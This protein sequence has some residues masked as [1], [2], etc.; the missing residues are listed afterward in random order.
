MEERNKE[1]NSGM[2]ENK[3]VIFSVI[4]P[5]YKVEYYLARCV[6]SLIQ[7]SVEKDQ[8]E[9]LLVDDGSPD[10]SGALCDEYAEKYLFVKAFHKENGGLSSARNYG[11]ERAS[12]EWILFVDSD[13]YVDK[14]LCRILQE[15]IQRYPGLDAVVYNGL[16]EEEET[17]SLMRSR[18]ETESV[19]SGKEYLLRHYKTR[20]LSVEACLYAYRREFLKSN[21]LQFKE[22]ILHEDVE[23][24]PRAM[25]QA[26][27]VLELDQPLYHYIIRGDSI[28]TAK[29]MQ[30]NIRDLY[31]TLEQQV[32]IAEHQPPELQKW[33][34]N[35][36]LD[37]Y[38]N[39]VQTARMYQKK[40]R[41]LL[42]KRFLWGKAATLWNHFR[43]LVCTCNVRLY[44]LMNDSYK[45][46]RG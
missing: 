32:R 9:I 37:S 34:K 21:Y 15:S 43:V 17:V 31:Q 19:S 46:L 42:K 2:V 35:A 6:D 1:V 3:T 41:P 33:M 11:M 14:D 38:L 5:V 27:Q 45:K 28:S 39:M 20:S 13:D 36:A 29:N 26:K 8:L 7:Q 18:A 23:F 44:C 16:E 24:T 40:Y 12:G 4:V 22:G 30:K 10:S 25:L